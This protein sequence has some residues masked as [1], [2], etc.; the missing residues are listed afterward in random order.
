[1]FLRAHWRALMAADLFT[2]EVWAGR[3]LVTY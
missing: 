2:I 3:G 1:V